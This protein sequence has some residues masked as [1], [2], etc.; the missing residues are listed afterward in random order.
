MDTTSNQVI[1]ELKKFADKNDLQALETASNLVG[2]EQ[3]IEQTSTSDLRNF[4]REKLILWLQVL[5]AIDSKMDPKFNVNDVPDLAVAP[6][7]GVQMPAGVDPNSISD[8]GIRSEYLKS[9]KANQTKAAYYSFQYQ[10]RKLSDQIFDDLSIYVQ[11]SHFRDNE[12]KTEFLKLVDK[13][14]TSHQRKT[15]LKALINSN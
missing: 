3:P 6:P 4:H 2:A 12:Q 10:L 1:L 7:P 5:N 14:A 11:K 13:I 15:D 8:H 9:I